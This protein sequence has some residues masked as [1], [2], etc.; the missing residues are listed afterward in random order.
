MALEAMPFS[1][2]GQFQQMDRRLLP[3]GP[4]KRAPIGAESKRP[5]AVG[6]EFIEQTNGVAGEDF[7]DRQV[8]PVAAVGNEP[9]VVRY[10]SG[11]AIAIAATFARGRR[12][13]AYRPIAHVKLQLRECELP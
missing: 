2:G 7:V 1:A 8:M 4:D 6:Q 5:R 9:T 12:Q 13:R 11:V 10:G 3:A